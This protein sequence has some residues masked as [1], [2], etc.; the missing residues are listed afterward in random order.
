VCSSL[1]NDWDHFKRINVVEGESISK[2]DLLHLISN[3]F[4]K[5]I[6]IIP[7][8][9]KGSDKS[10]SGEIKSAGIKDQL[11]ELKEFY[12]PCEYYS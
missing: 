11:I 8:S 3:L 9:G 7:M 4:N 10:L 2:Y 6:E 1:I 12:Y 5:Q